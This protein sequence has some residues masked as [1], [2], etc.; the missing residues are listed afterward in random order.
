MD[1]IRTGKMKQVIAQMTEQLCNSEIIDGE[2]LLISSET[3]SCAQGRMR[4]MG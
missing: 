3:G 4:Y 2:Q 1:R